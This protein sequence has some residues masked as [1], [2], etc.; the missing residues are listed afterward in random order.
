MAVAT[1]ATFNPAAEF[2][3][4]AAYQIMGVINEDEIPTAGQYKW[5]S[6]PSIR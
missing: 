4:Q 3:M 5:R 2:I 1:T 6:I